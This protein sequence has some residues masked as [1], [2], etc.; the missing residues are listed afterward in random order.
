MWKRLAGTGSCVSEDRVP[1]LSS[2]EGRSSR[3]CTLEWTVLKL[4]T[5]GANLGP[6]D[7]ER[8]SRASPGEDDPKSDYDSLNL[9]RLLEKMDGR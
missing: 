8:R 3:N 5:L 4:G 9:W 6:Y 2:E 1:N 7:A